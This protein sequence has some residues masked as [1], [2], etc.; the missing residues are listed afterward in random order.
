MEEDLTNV[1]VASPAVY[2]EGVPHDV[3]AR[4]RAED[5]VHW[6]PWPGHGG[7]FWLLTKHA[8][9]VE[10][11]TPRSRRSSASGRRSSTSAARPRAIR[12]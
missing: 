4:L 3:L 8:D 11:G 9:V 12:R 7:G 5:P 10:V 2:G 1:D 6:H